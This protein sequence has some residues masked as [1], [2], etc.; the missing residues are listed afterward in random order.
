MNIN[1]VTSSDWQLSLYEADKLVQEI[2][3]IRQC[4]DIILNTQVGSDPLRPTFGTNYL[5]H[6][7]GPVNTTAP[8]MLQEIV[9]AVQNWEQRITIDRA[10]WQIENST[11][12]YQIYW[13]CKYGKGVN[14]LSL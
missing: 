13:S 6:I 9:T 3:D 5:K 12:V 7:D 2:D 11:I 4:V 8:R 10:T 1:E 14:F